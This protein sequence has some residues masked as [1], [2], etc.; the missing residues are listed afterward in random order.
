MSKADKLK[1]LLRGKKPT[2]GTNPSDP[3]S[4][5]AGLAESE[6]GLLKKFLK[7]R[8]INPEYVS[9]DQKIAHSKTGQFAKWKQSHLN[10][11]AE[12]ITTEPT[13]VQK[14]EIGRAHV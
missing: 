11:V 5:K 9:K 14:R 4:A 6:A 10:D 2:F 3:W 12:S 7:S 13:P 1:E 8:G